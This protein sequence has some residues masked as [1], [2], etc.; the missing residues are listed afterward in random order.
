MKAGIVIEEYKLEVFSRHLTQAGYAFQ[1]SGLIE[2]TYLTLTVA[3]DNPIALTAVVENA[4]AESVNIGV[5][6]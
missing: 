4:M 1:K 5:L 6:Q 2:G 3:T